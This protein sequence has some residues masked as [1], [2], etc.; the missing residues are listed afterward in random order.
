MKNDFSARYSTA[1]Y[2]QH[3]L[4]YICK[5]PKSVDIYV[6]KESSS[7]ALLRVLGPTAQETLCS[8]NPHLILVLLINP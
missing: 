7:K 3:A 2:K 8:R 1:L 5:T 4:I 6:A